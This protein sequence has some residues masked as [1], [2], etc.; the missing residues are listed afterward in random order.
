[1]LQIALQF[2]LLFMIQCVDLMEKHTAMNVFLKWQ[3]VS[4]QEV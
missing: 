2:A 1:M 3:F 4:Q